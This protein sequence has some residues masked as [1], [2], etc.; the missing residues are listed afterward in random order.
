M[1]RWN[2]PNWL[3]TAVFERDKVC[4]YCGIIFNDEPRS[5]RERR[6][7]E[8]ITNNAKIITLENI[9][10]CC[11]GC[12]SSKGVKFLE[13]WLDSSYCKRKNIS[14][15]TVAQVVKDALLNPPALVA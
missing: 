10:L 15:D 4:I 6:S 7:W 8:H 3:E 13:T 9:A 12:N 11:R 5:F 1:N 2:I 14:K